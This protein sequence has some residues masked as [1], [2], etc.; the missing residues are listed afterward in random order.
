M[1]VQTF[2]AVLTGSLGLLSD[3]IHMLLDCIALVVGLIAAV[4]SKWPPS[5]RFPYGF[6]KVDTLAGFANGVFLMLISVE[7]IYEAIER[8]V[9][10]TRMQRLGELFI[11]SLL[12]LM[13]NLVGMFCFGH[14][15]AH[16]GHDHSHG[17]HHE[18][19]PAHSH[20]HDH[21]H[22]HDDELNGHAHMPEGL[23]HVP[24]TPMSASI[25][26]TPSKPLNGH[27]QHSHSHDYSHSPTHAHS[28]D[29]SHG[30]S[31]S[32][33]H[34]GNEN[35]HGLF[36]HVLADTLGSVSVVISTIL[37][38]Y[39][40]WFGWDALA[41]VLIAVLIFISAIPLVRSSAKGLLLTIPETTEF[42]LREALGDVGGLRG[43][44]A[45][46]AP[47]FWMRDG[48]GFGDVQ[49][50]MHV[51]AVRAADLDD[52]MERA[53]RTLGSRGLDVLVQVEREGETRCWCG[54]GAR[55]T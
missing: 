30:H 50:V 14:A 45:V 17:H 10:G 8:F 52:V 13:V 5:P 32:H 33:H 44:V 35:M 1:L 11:V 53:K 38:H 26:P 47:R 31:H 27:A 9:D 40:G 18:H 41:S 43:V 16:P 37:I 48:P 39:T 23:H 34:H 29:H 21:F 20:E 55:I 3:S 22:G 25:P 28:H 54:S 42:D 46:S 51:V 4:M 6:G 12:G 49:G 19:A 24:P 7:I 2:Y 36:L 15:H